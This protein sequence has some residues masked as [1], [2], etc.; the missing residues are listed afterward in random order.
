MKHPVSKGLYAGLA[1]DQLRICESI[2]SIAT[3]AAGD[4]IFHDGDLGDCMY[5]V[6]RGSVGITK[7]P[8][9]SA[10]LLLDLIGEGDYFGEMCLVDNQPRSANAVAQEQTELRVLR[11]EDLEK[12]MGVAPQTVLTLLKTNSQRLRQMNT[13]YINQILLQAKLSLIGQMAGS[14]IHDFRN[15]ITVIEM[16][17]EKLMSRRNDPETTNVCNSII[18][19]VDRITYMAN[20][21]LEFARGNV[22]IDVQPTQ[23]GPWIG[24]LA[25]M[26]KP[27]LESN[28]VRFQQ[29]V[30][31]DL[32]LT[33][34][35]NKMTRVLYNL[36]TN[37]IQ[38]MPNGGSVTIGI[39]QRDDETHIDIVDTGPGI[40]EQ[41]RDRLFE[42]FVTYGKASGTGLGTA[43]AKKIVEE[44]GGEI[45]FTTESGTGTTFHI[46]LPVVTRVAAVTPNQAVG[47]GSLS[48]PIQA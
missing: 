23:A 34:D 2:G 3:F 29:E 24:E 6:L 13:Q 25:E 36:T 39:E 9:G 48:G 32:L 35:A 42:M 28:R 44:H 22:T 14:I 31:A 33:I 7:T 41:I 40:P 45:S 20:D 17:A 15:P 18:R 10:P 27:M 30:P 12:L 43:I 26:L 19:N 8:A 47:A 11:R 16:Q 4:A 1:A 38:A 5:V 21:L 46:A 37:A